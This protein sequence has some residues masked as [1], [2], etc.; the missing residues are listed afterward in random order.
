MRRDLC[1]SAKK[2]R[3]CIDDLCRHND[4]TLCGFS[5]SEYEDIMGLCGFCGAERGDPCES[6][7]DCIECRDGGG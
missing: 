6:N 5:P 7:C 4:P 2:G 3:A 1:D